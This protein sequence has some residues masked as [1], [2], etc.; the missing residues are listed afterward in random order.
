MILGLRGY[1]VQ[2]AENGPDGLRLALAWKPD[3]V[4]S[5]IGL[6]GMDGWQLARRLREALGGTITLIALSAY[7]SQADLARSQEAG[8]DIHFVKPVELHE[9]FALLPAARGMAA[10]SPHRT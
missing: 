6:P 10:Q 5:D 1:R 2:V 3:V 8:F 9:L 4:V 7:G